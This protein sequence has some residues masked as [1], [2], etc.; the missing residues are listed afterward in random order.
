MNSACLPFS[1]RALRSI[2]NLLTILLHTRLQ[3][4]LC[5]LATLAAGCLLAAAQPAYAA[6]PCTATSGPARQALLELYTSEGCNSCPPAEAWLSKIGAETPGVVPLALHVDYWD[7]RAWRDRFDDPRFTARQ[8]A[9]SARGG[10]GFVYT[11]EV[12][13]SGGELR[14]WDS[15]SAFSAALSRI[16]AQP[17]PVRIQLML[18][19]S[20]GQRSVDA[21]IIPT[22]GAKRL[23][24]QA[25]LA[26]YENHLV[27]R[28]GGGENDGATLHHE[29]VVRQ[30]LGP[31]AL[32]AGSGKFQQGVNLAPEGAMPAAGQVGVVAFV[33]AADGE[34]LQALALPACE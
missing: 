31:L 16:A 6:G 2:L 3:G 28:I 13:V 4:L 18:S 29:F 25:Y 15:A 5:V 22:A 33:E 11:P 24:A 30:W 12:A 26:V 10:S 34:V 20:G 17:S 23:G 21:R 8:Q 32:T 9:L 1:L 14:N 27:S 7:S 19:G